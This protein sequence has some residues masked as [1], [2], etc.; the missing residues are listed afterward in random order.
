LN[1]ALVQNGPN[2]ISGAAVPMFGRV[3]VSLGI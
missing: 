1:E 3:G 2:F